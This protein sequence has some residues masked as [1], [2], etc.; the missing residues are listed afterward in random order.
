MSKNSPAPT[1]GK[2]AKKMIREN[3]CVSFFGGSSPLYSRLRA[4]GYF[5]KF[6]RLDFNLLTNFALG[7]CECNGIM[8]DAVNRHSKAKLQ[9]LVPISFDFQR[10]LCPN[11]KK[12]LIEIE[13]AGTRDQT[14]VICS[15][16]AKHWNS[17]RTL[18]DTSTII[19]LKAA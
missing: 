18:L 4:T 1:S 8:R 14:R 6:N 10:L 15:S 5:T 19:R 3:Q 12:P 9:Q 16:P 11:L 13:W 17:F 7:H 2:L